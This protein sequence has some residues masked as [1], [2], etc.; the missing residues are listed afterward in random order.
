[1]KDA[2]RT[3]S[4]RRSGQRFDAEHGIVTE[5][6]I[7]LGELDPSAIGAALEDATHYEPTPLAQFDALLHAVP[8]SAQEQT[9]VDIGAGMG[10]IVLL[11]SLHP[12]RQILGVEVS[13]ALCETA[14][15]NLAVWRRRR[16][17]I[18]CR[19]VR[20][21]CKDALQTPVPGGDVVFY[22]YNPFGEAS[23]RRLADRIAAESSGRV[24]LIYHTPVHRNVLDAH[25]AFSL[26]EDL[27]F[28]LIYEGR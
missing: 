3:T 24:T 5:A 19:D 28:G 8:L 22:L 15:E 11:A 1:M 16:A 27:K 17:D 23:L 9:F 25:P 2:R 18:A 7:F 26:L 6:L 4:G 20:I 12:F 10:R 13:P 14:R 21:V